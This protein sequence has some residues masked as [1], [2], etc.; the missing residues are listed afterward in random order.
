MS[1]SFTIS[2]FK[3]LTAP[4][5]FDYSASQ[6]AETAKIIAWFDSVLQDF[7][8]QLN[9]IDLTFRQWRT[10]DYT[11]VASSQLLYLYYQS[12]SL[13]FSFVQ[14]N[15]NT[16]RDL[17]AYLDSPRPGSFSA[18]ISQLYNFL[19][20]IG[21]TSGIGTLTAGK[22]NPINY[23]ETFI[24]YSSS[25]T[26]PATPGGVAYV[27]HGWATPAGW[28]R[29]PASSTYVSRGYLYGASIIW[30]PPVSTATPPAYYNVAAL[31]DLPAANDGDVGSVYADGSGDRSALYTYY[32][33]TWY[34][35]SSENNL[36]GSVIT[37]TYLT[38]SGVFAPDTLPP[39]TSLTQPPPAGPTQ[40]YGFYGLYGVNLLT[41]EI[42]AVITLTA[43]GEANLGIILT[44][45][46][47]I[48]PATT[49][50]FYLYVVYLSTVTSYQIKDTE[51]IN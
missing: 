49:F 38:G 41:E 13:G 26:P 43:N 51:S 12:Q 34:K 28:T 33:G 42:D 29:A 6:T 48:K 25:L 11:G 7:E 24:I 20:A 37:D 16:E 35:C 17:L 22:G 50:A 23:A 19:F 15:L 18:C 31:G 3:A 5:Y 4:G 40:G 21:W 46:Q 9:L 27:R 30:L 36:Q 32:S 1:Y 44:L 10:R 45:F 14:P 2:K 47:R 8:D 39:V